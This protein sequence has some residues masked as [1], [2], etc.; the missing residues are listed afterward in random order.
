[1]ISSNSIQLNINSLDGLK[2]LLNNYKVCPTNWIKSVNALYNEVTKG[3]CTL[4]IKNER[5][6]SHVNGV[7][8]KCFYTNDQGEKY[9]LFEEKQVFK[10]GQ[11]RE[12]G[13]KFIAEKI[14]SNESPE[15]AALRGLAE[16]LKIFG[17]KVSL[18]PLFEENKC[19]TVDSPDYKGIQT[20]YCTNVFL[21]EISPTHYKDFYVEDQEDKQTFF[22][23]VKI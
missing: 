21:C 6:H 13:H 4:S 12:R 14:Q 2:E 11:T 8:I 16:E 18:T 5:L 15:Q 1:M 7:V 9:Q 23:W 17:P 20:T 10:N 22:S 19:D 3:D